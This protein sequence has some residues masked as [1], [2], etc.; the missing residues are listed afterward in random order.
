MP[1]VYKCSDCIGDYVTCKECCLLAHMDLPFHRL[2]VWKNEFFQKTSLFELGYII[3]LGHGGNKCPSCPA[4]FP[5]HL[6]TPSSSQT[7]AGDVSGEPVPSITDLFLNAGSAAE[8]EEEWHEESEAEPE[9]T[10]SRLFTSNPP[11]LDKQDKVM[12]I[13]DASGIHRH[14]IRWCTCP[15][16]VPYHLQLFRLG[17]FPSSFH[18]PATAFSFNVL[19]DFVL[20]TLECKTAALNYFGKL[21]RVTDNEFP[22]SVP[23]SGIFGDC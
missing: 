20:E 22:D 11:H 1:G 23:V 18:R 17:L 16:S 19:E 5:I 6:P 21:R 9:L 12:V 8:P 2:A 4:N 3:H 7:L 14:T 15:D 10:G 13:V